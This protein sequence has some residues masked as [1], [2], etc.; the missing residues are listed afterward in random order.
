MQPRSVFNNVYRYLL[1][2]RR[3]RTGRRG[4]T[5]AVLPKRGEITPASDRTPSPKVPT[6]LLP[7]SPQAGAGTSE[8]QSPIRRVQ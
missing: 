8:T 4:Q 2:Q 5:G 7:G 3:N 1:R 6:V